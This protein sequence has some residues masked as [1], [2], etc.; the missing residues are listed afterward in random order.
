MTRHV[1]TQRWLFSRVV[2]VLF[3][4]LSTLVIVRFAWTFPRS[5]V[6]WHVSDLDV[7][8]GYLLFFF[9]AVLFVHVTFCM[10]TIL[11]DYVHMPLIFVVLVWLL[12]TV[13]LVMGGVACLKIFS[14]MAVI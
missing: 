7:L 10:E 1:S 8:D 3:L 12:R 2:A 14:M 9:T 4:V 6:L 5:S 11:E 13:S